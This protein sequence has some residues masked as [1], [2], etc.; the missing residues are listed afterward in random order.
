M[1]PET[2]YSAAIEAL[3]EAIRP[4]DEPGKGI[5]YAYGLYRG[6]WGYMEVVRAR[7]ALRRVRDAMV[8]E[9]LRVEWA[10]NQ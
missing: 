10:A 1:Q 8:A 2:S 7:D 5:G 4:L 9:G 3:N 6:Q